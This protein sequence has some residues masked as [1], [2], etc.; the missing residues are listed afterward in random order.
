MMDELYERVRWV[1]GSRSD[2]PLYVVCLG[3]LCVF[4]EIY[5]L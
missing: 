5:L 1:I 3:A 4:E 2:G